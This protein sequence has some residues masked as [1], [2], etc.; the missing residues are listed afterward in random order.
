MNG[1]IEVTLTFSGDR[2][3]KLT[4]KDV[5]YKELILLMFK[6]RQSWKTVEVNEESGFVRLMPDMPKVNTE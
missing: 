3:V 1:Q 5:E 4:A 6:H 2:E